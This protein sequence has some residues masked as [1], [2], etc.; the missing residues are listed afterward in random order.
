MHVAHIHEPDTDPSDDFL[1][2]PSAPSGRLRL[3]LEA[4]LARESRA[5]GP[6]G[7]WREGLWFPSNNERRPCCEGL[8][9]TLANKQALESHC[10]SAAHVAALFEVPVL[11]LRRALKRARVAQEAAPSQ[12]AGAP[13]RQMTNTERLAR[14]SRAALFEALA[15]LRAEARQGAGVLKEL[16]DLDEEPAGDL[17]ATLKIAAERLKLVTQSLE[18]ATQMELVCRVSELALGKV[19]ALEP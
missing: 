11:D 19:R 8:Q 1:G 12:P 3:A 9:P 13:G 17:A 5:Q 6:E 4:F 7:E 15:T 2:S 18:S 16:A 14:V 10:R